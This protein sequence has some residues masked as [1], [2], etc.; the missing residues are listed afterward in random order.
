[1]VVTNKHSFALLNKNYVLFY[2]NKKSP[3]RSFYL[4]FKEKYCSL[5]VIRGGFMLF[6]NLLKKKHSSFSKQFQKGMTLIEILF[7]I[8]LIGGIMFAIIPQVM[9]GFD[10][11]NVKTT[12][13]AMKAIKEQLESYLSDCQKYPSNLRA[14]IEDPGPTECSGYI[15]PYLEARQLKDAWSADFIYELVDGHP[16]VKS[17]GKDK[18]PGGTGV[19][20]DLSTDDE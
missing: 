18:K 17:L 19:N 8:A 2:L 20:K 6:T 14:L 13:L 1:M 10:K 11:G 5:C 4:S 9:K 7:V 16:V 15:N 3:K 12:K